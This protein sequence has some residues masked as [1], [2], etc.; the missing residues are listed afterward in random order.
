M[1]LT[2]LHKLCL[3][4]LIVTYEQW[5]DA[6]IALTDARADLEAARKNLTEENLLLE[7][8]AVEYN[9][10]TYLL[11]IDVDGDS[12]HQVAQICNPISIDTLSNGD[13]TMENNA[14]ID[15]DE[16]LF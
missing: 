10:K 8:L 9:G 11:T 2:E 1:E 16:V 13:G 7:E 4:R 15:E 6:E 14:G 12:A 3:K 5:V